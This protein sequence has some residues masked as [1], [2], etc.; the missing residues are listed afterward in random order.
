MVVQPLPLA[1]LEEDLEGP[2]VHQT[3]FGAPHCHVS[4]ESH[5]SSLLPAHVDASCS[6]PQMDMP[7]KH[8]LKSGHAWPTQATQ[9]PSLRCV[10]DFKCMLSR[11][12]DSRPAGCEAAVYPARVS[13]GAA[14]RKPTECCLCCLALFQLP[15]GNDAWP[16]S[17]NQLSISRVLWLLFFGDTHSFGC[18]CQ[19]VEKSLERLSG[20]TGNFF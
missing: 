20:S 7:H 5:C 18:S 6:M 3:V 16:T 15:S 8:G 4:A 10:L 19:G 9:P 17:R 14:A 12:L 1:L 11:I 13:T 2:D